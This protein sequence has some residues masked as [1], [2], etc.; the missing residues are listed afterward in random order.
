MVLTGESNVVYK[1]KR[2]LLRLCSECVL[3]CYYHNIHHSELN[4]S[5][6]LLRIDC[7]DREK[8]PVQIRTSSV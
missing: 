8:V 7:L 1:R 5:I 4:R 3:S 6:E 2:S